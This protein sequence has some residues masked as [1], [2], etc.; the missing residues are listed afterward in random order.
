[1]GYFDRRNSR[2]GDAFGE[3]FSPEEPRS[4]YS[5]LQ[6]ETRDAFT[7]PEVEERG[8]VQPEPEEPRQRSS[9]QRPGTPSL[10]AYRN[11]L[12]SVPRSENYKPSGWTRVAAG[13]A[14]AAAGIRDPGA[15]I[16]TAMGLN[17]SR[18]DQAVDEY[19]RQGRGLGAAAGI[20]R[21][22][23]NDDLDYRQ[24]REQTDYNYAQLARLYGKD[25]ADE[26]FRN[27]QQNFTEWK[28]E[29][30]V[31]NDWRRTNNDT[32]NTNS[33]VAYRQGQLRL[34]GRNA[35]VGE[36]NARTNAANV[37]SLSG[38][39]NSQAQN[40]KARTDNLTRQT[41]YNVGKPY[42]DS[43]D[44]STAQQDAMAD[45]KADYPQ[46]IEMGA[47]GKS[48]EFSE[49]PDVGTPEYEAYTD[50]IREVE[51]RTKDRSMGNPG[52][53]TEPPDTWRRIP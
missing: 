1:M 20:E 22:S 25:K 36:S 39:R 9:Y 45:I 38:Y 5:Q 21:Q 31:Q 46:F 8:Y 3:L 13:I 19:D 44:L 29:S 6:E 53:G 34:G 43:A 28:G 10:D 7:P 37:S 23:I 4:R 32:T 35:A 16:N 17:R 52:M 42:T 41:N 12:S 18:Y 40:D 27:R 26:Y 24:R 47:D 2:V 15:G 11:H 49:P 14:G 48:F 50:M 33:N 51:R 30:D